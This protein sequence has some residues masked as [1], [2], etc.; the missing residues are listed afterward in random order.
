MEFSLLPCNGLGWL[1]SLTLSS[2]SE[3]GIFLQRIGV[4]RITDFVSTSYPVPTL[5][6]W[7]SSYHRF[8]PD[9]QRRHLSSPAMVS[10][11][12]WTRVARVIDCVFTCYGTLPAMDQCGSFHCFSLHLLIMVFFP[13]WI[14]VA[15]MTIS[16]STCYGVL[17]ATWQWIGVACI[18]DFVF[19]F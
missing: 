15:L 14:G 12:R 17:P 1:A 3:G 9:L 4:A 2:P 7:G 18:T 13:R 11:L 6:G 16:V 19:T 8:C 10:F 5:M